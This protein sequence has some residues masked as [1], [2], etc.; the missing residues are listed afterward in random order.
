MFIIFDDQN[1]LTI[2]NSL[3]QRIDINCIVLS[4]KHKDRPDKAI[5]F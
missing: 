1:V 3:L 2:N 4:M 5:I